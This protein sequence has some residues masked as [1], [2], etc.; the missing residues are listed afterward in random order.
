MV[1]V[2]KTESLLFCLRDDPLTVFRKQN[3]V[4]FIFRKMMSHDLLVQV[5]YLPVPIS[6]PD[7]DDDGDAQHG[8][9][10]YSLIISC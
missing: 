3:Q 2:W 10:N 1:R 6:T 9:Q 7:D 4:T 8:G 5:A